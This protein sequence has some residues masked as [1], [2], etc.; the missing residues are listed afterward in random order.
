MTEQTQIAQP[1]DAATGPLC[2][3]CGEPTGPN[4]SH[5]GPRDG[6]E[7]H[8]HIGNHV[9]PLGRSCLMGFVCSVTFN[10]PEGSDF[11]EDD[12]DDE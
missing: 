11:E 7:L 8:L 6:S 9:G 5:P 1:S 4:D 2:R 3:M 12:S 10:N